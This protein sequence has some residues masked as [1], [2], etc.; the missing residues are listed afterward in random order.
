MTEIN[1][2]INRLEFCKKYGRLGGHDCNG[3]YERYTE[4][5]QAIALVD[6]HRS[7]CHYGKCKTGCIVTMVDDIIAVLKEQNP[8][9][10]HWII[11]GR[12]NAYGGIE[13]VCSECDNYVMVQNVED[14]LFC[15]HCG[16]KMKEFAWD[17]FPDTIC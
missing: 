4:D 6:E 12:K 15:R 17:R 9:Q 3:H 2:V 10:G 8:K 7:E 13:I 5:G 14:E 16:A 11:T 1:D